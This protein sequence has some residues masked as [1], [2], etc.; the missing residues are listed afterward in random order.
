MPGFGI[1]NLGKKNGNYFGGGF[2]FHQ[3]IEN[4]DF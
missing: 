4:F 3:N 1:Q 2:I